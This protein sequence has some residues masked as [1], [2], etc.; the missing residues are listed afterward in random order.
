MATSR[1]GKAG[2]KRRQ[3]L[4]GGVVTKAER[5]SC[6]FALAIFGLS[7]TVAVSVA[8]AVGVA[9]GVAVAAVAGLQFNS[10]SAYL[11]RILKCFLLCVAQLGHKTSH[12]S[13]G[14]QRNTPKGSQRE[15]EEGG[16]GG[17]RK[18]L[19]SCLGGLPKQMAKAHDI[20]GVSECISFSPLSPVCLPRDEQ[21]HSRL[22]ISVT[23]ASSDKKRVLF[24]FLKLNRVKGLH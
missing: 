21:R 5:L 15:R 23:G 9:V 20:R 14:E 3:C 18:L 16:G 17:W 13:K 12:A 6:G 7:A 24:L 4:G 1:R 11:Q 19:L 10:L 22:A 2:S 8:A